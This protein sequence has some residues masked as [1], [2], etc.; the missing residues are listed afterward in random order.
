ME[1]KRKTL[2]DALQKLLGTPLV[3][4]DFV[5]DYM[6]LEWE[7][8]FLTAHT[9]PVLLIAGLEY[10]EENYDYRSVM[11]R[12]EGQR[13]LRAEVIEGEV[14][15]LFFANETLFTISLRDADYI[16]AEA[17]LYRDADGQL[18]VA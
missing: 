7:K 5:Q 14:L 2:N 17:F 16:T 10:R 3:S 13:L 8:S 15:S 11:Y 6:Q 4:V 12:L 9:M 18:W 1:L